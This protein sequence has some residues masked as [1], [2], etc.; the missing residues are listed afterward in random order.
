[1]PKNDFSA[2]DAM[3]T[4]ALQE[5]LRTDFF[6]SEGEGYGTDAVL[7]IMQVIAERETGHPSVYEAW[8]IF[9]KYYRSNNCNGTSLYDE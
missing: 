7:Y 3:S 6:M 8:R 1:M 5:I 2:F 9:N 4:E